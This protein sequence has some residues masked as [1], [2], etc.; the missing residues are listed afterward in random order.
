MKAIVFEIDLSQERHPRDFWYIYRKIAFLRQS[1][2]IKV[3]LH[4][5]HPCIKAYENGKRNALKRK[6]QENMESYL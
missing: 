1:K 3:K 5:Y 6:F 4:E 2:N